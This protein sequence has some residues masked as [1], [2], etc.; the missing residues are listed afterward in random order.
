[1]IPEDHIILFKFLTTNNNTK[2]Q[3]ERYFVRPSAGKMTSD[4]QADIMLFLNQVPAEPVKDKIIVRWA[5]V[6]RHTVIEDWV[7]SLHDSTRRK[8]IDMLDEEWPD[9]VTIRMTRI[10]IRFK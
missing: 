5:A 10:K 7:H 3:P 4:E 6:Q 9:Q 2:G 1:M 8:W